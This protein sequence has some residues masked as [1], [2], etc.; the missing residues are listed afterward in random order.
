MRRASTIA[1]VLLIVFIFVSSASA[2]SFLPRTSI[3]GTV[4]DLT[5]SPLPG[6]SI[7]IT[8]EETGFERFVISNAAG[9][10]RALILPEGRYRLLFQ[11]RGFKQL[12]IAGVETALGRPTVVDAGLSVGD[13]G[14]IQTRRFDAPVRSRAAQFEPGQNFASGELDILPLPTRNP[15][16]AVLFDSNVAGA[17]VAG[18]PEPITNVNGLPYRSHFLVDGVSDSSASSG[19]GLLVPLPEM[20]VAGATPASAAYPAESGRT[21]GVLYNA[22]TPDGGAKTHGGVRYLFR[23]DRFSAHEPSVDD[24][25]VSPPAQLDDVFA[26]IGGPIPAAGLRYFG[27]YERLSNDLRFEP[28]LQSLLQGSSTTSSAFGQ[29]GFWFG[30][31]T[32]VS[33]RHLNVQRNAS[34]SDLLAFEPSLDSSSHSTLFSLTTLI[35]ARRLNDLRMQYASNT[36]ALIV[37]TPLLTVP[38]QQPALG[39]RVLEIADAFS[40]IRNNHT[41]K[42]GFDQS[43][44][45]TDV[46]SGAGDVTLRP[47][48][49]AYYLE[50][51]W[52]VNGSL[53]LLYGIRYDLYALP[54]GFDGS[55]TNNIGPRF[56]L[57][58]T[59]GAA[60]VIRATTGITYD[61]PMVGLLE[62]VTVAPDFE[63]A[64]SWQ[65]SV[66]VE[67]GLGGHYSADVTYVFARHRHLPVLSE[68]DVD[69]LTAFT[70]SVVL[71]SS[72]SAH[73]DGLSLRLRRRFVNGFGFSVAYTAAGPAAPIL[74][75]NAFTGT[76]TY[77]VPPARDAS[78]GEGLRTGHEIGVVIRAANGVPANP[79]DSRD[80]PGMSNVDVR[81]AK[82]FAVRGSVSV[83]FIA[84]LANIFNSDQRFSIPPIV[85]ATVSA[86]GANDFFTR[87]GPPRQLQLGLRLRF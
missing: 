70:P 5:G 32:R 44:L 54:V 2:Q 85:P 46:P 31:G 42:V 79:Q 21:S 57:S 59:P 87:T 14:D 86:A 68:P 41:Y 16:D 55:D 33:L 23:R 80:L 35:G 66:N 11:I 40:F 13:F 76:L 9:L 3:E 75:A 67:Q 8:D 10:F 52:R 27:G 28:A 62:R 19:F 61:D 30:T 29:A 17:A 53:R 1:I 37:E 18:W 43:W 34:L 56:A 82:R 83:D 39:E 4:T 77:V 63:V 45:Q 38:W 64:S 6:V 49:R 69:S 15:A 58:W 74:P 26:T 48:L 72:E 22:I 60:T 50:D 71:D 47:G 84:E 78:L 7:V 36:R 65:N 81:Y 20:A 51:D 73:Y 12:A 24:A 25:T